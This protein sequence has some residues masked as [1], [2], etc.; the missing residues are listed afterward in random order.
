MLDSFIEC[1]LD[2]QG[3]CT[4]VEHRLQVSSDFE[5]KRLREYHIPELLREE[6]QSQIDGLI[7]DGFI[8]P[9]TSPM[10]SP[11]VCVLKGREGK[12]GVRLAI[13][14]RYVN[15]FTQTHMLCLT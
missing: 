13:D 6:V 7:K 8:V 12:A 2:K 14:Y 9:S 3:L 5:P 10:A 15:R 1:F 11:L 4:Y